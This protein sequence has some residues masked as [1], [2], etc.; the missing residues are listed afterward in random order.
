MFLFPYTFSLGIL[1]IYVFVPLALLAY[2]CIAIVELCTHRC[3]LSFSLVYF[4]FVNLFMKIT[5][6]QCLFL[7]QTIRKTAPTSFTT[8][9]EMKLII[10]QFMEPLTTTK[11]S[12][13][14]LIVALSCCVGLLRGKVFSAVMAF[15]P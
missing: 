8:L 9:S 11:I 5:N 15:A 2:H 3:A 13:R 6:R 12:S 10:R 14:L 1:K 7:G 4:S